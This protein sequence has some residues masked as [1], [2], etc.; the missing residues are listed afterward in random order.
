ML[1]RTHIHQCA[2]EVIRARHWTLANRSRFPGRT[3]NAKRFKKIST[4]ITGSG[5]KL[6]L[7]RFEVAYFR[8]RTVSAEQYRAVVRLLELFAEHLSLMVNQIALHECN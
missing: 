8:F 5:M 1:C 4:Q 7:P 2:A 3:P 6:N